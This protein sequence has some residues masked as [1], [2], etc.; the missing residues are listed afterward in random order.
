MRLID[1]NDLLEDAAFNP[2][3]EDDG[4]LTKEIREFYRESVQERGV[5]PAVR[6]A[7]LKETEDGYEIIKVFE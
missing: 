4:F 6:V 1:E 2:E 5:A 7:L 3:E